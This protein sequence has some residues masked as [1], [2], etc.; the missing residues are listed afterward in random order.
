METHS[1]SWTI[2]MSVEFTHLKSWPPMFILSAFHLLP[3]T[4][5]TV[6][7]LMQ[8]FVHLNLGKIDRGHISVKAI[9]YALISSLWN[10]SK[11][12]IRVLITTHMIIL[13]ALA[14]SSANMESLSFL[15][16][17]PPH[18]IFLIFRLLEAKQSFQE[19]DIVSLNREY[20]TAGLCWGSVRSVHGY[21]VV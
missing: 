10:S 6:S 4:V 2:Q 17:L 12:L 20:Y 9:R 5:P 1:R 11:Q 16:F 13:I 7:S 21:I 3:T 14:I 19:L 15:F 8:N 18:P